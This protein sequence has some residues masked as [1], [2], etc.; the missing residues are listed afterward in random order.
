L[1]A[2]GGSTELENYL[3]KRTGGI[4]DGNLSVLSSIGSGENSYAT[5]LN[6][7]AFGEAVSALADASFAEGR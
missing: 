7:A 2:A 1:I 3:D 4:I 5:G 6:S